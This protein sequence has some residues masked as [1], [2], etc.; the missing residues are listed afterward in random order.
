MARYLFIANYASDG[1]KGVTK[2][3]GTARRTAIQALASQLGGRMESF[4]FAFGNDDVY[5]VVELPDNK[6]AAAVA[7]AVNSTGLVSVRT[8]VLMTPEE[9]D[10]AT[11][12]TGNYTPP[13]G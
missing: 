2:T 4:D 7:L 13:G 5:T 3:G 9:I 1:I 12:E 8:V 6:A 11:S 10:A